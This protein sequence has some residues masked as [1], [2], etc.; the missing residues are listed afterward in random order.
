M[1]RNRRNLNEWNQLDPETHKGPISYLGTLFLIVLVL[2]LG[3]GA[4]SYVVGYF[5][6]GAQVVK[7]ETSPRALLKKYQW[8]KDVS[9]QLDAKKKNIEAQQARLTGL[10]DAYKVDGKPQPRNQWA[11]TDL[12]QYNQVQ[13]EISGMK[14]SFND[15]AAEY[16]AA[17][18]KINFAFINVGQLPQGVTEALPREFKPYQ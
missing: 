10:E 17:M 18:V 5:Q 3:I 13:A 2:S 7:E 9:A 12:E 14:A 8:F 1:S 4:I 15:L 6:E 11:R 16:N